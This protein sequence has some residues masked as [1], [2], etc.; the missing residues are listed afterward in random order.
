KLSSIVSWTLFDGGTAKI[1]PEKFN[2]PR[3]K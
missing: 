1:S 2:I 3:L